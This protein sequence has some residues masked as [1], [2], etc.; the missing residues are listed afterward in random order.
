MEARISPDFP[1]LFDAMRGSEMNQW[2]GGADPEL[3]G[4]ICATL[5][6][7]HVPIMGGERA[8]DFGCGIGRVALALLRQRP[9][10]GSLTGFDIVPRVVEFCRATIGPH[11]PNVNFEVLADRNAHYERFKDA[12][13]PRSRDDLTAAYSGS[14]DFAYAY[15]VFTHIDTSDFVPLLRFVGGLLKP[16]G[17]FL[18][19]AYALTPY[20]RHQIARRA[21]TNRVE[22]GHYEQD[23]DVFIAN[24]EDRL[25]FIGY[26]I[27]RIE[28]IIWEAGLIPCAVEYGDWRGDKMCDSFQDIFVCRRPGEESPS[29][30]ITDGA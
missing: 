6:L 9:A 7:R 25:A 5:L 17:R 20:S 29:P 1:R 22:R 13:A 18:F 19:T 30:G 14:F 24:P 8:L 28:T 3:V 23:G 16:K 26:D 15:S 11:F 2:V 27:R 21:T 12:T 4:D 10:L